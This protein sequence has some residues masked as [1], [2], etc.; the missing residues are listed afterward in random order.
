MGDYLEFLEGYFGGVHGA[1]GEGAEAAV[2]VEVDVFGREVVEGVFDL[3]DDVVDGFH[4]VDAGVDDSEADFLDAIGGGEGLDL[5]SAGGGVFED[6]L[7][8]L[9]VGDVG[10]KGGVGAVEECFFLA[11]PVATADRGR[12]S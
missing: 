10:E 3:A 4:F 2:G 7:V 12:R 6:K 5:A 1:F 9:V 8:N 11:A